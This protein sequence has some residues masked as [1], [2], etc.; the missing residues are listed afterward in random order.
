MDD[1]KYFD[2]IQ[3]IKEIISQ[4]DGGK[5]PPQEAKKQFKKAKGLIDECEEI[6]NRYSGTVE[7][8][9]IISLGH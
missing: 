2:N 6:L 9:S 3:R 5:L 8:I 1:I 7:E 4:L